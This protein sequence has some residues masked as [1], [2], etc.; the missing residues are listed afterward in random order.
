MIHCF[1]HFLGDH[2]F[3]ENS[4]HVLCWD[5]GF[6]YQL[7]LPLLTMQMCQT[8]IHKTV[9]QDILNNHQVCVLNFNKGTIIV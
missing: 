3:L 4:P 7:D 8:A 6:F 1:E 5:W 2:N 9:N